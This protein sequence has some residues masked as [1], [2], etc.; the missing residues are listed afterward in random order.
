MTG[1]LRSR[2]LDGQH[3]WGRY[4][5]RPVD[6]TM[7][8][9]TTLVVHP[10]GASRSERIRLRVW[11]AWPGL[12]ALAAI[13]T[14]A[15]LGAWPVVRTVAA[16]AVYAAGFA[17]LARTTRRLRPQVRS[18]TVTTF[19]GHGRPEV[20][21]DVPTLRWAHDALTAAERS[22]TSG[23]SRPVDFEAAWAEVWN[24]LPPRPTVRL[25]PRDRGSRRSASSPR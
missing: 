20:H 19:H 2:V 6:R 9:T 17:V 10:P 3:V 1:R 21:G 13:A 24:V 16:V 14:M 22:L 12:G 15:G 4:S 8:S 18:V 23:G 7:W 25:S 5:V 11:S